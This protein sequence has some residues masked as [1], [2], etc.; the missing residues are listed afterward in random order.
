MLLPDRSHQYETALQR[1]YD[2]VH[3]PTLL[4]LSR[5]WYTKANK[6]GN[7]SAMRFAL[8]YAQ[9]VR[10]NL[11]HLVLPSLSRLT[12]FPSSEPSQALHINPSD[13]AIL[14]NVAMIQQKAAEMLVALPVDK[15]S[16]SEL[17]IAIEQATHAQKS[18]SSSPSPASTWSL[19][20]GL[21]DLTLS[22]PPPPPGSSLV[23]QDLPHAR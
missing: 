1:F 15:R 7:F 20:L 17:K 8:R 11:A 19:A 13:K 9:K 21:L 18:V 2:G 23:N 16:L 5:T 3:A 6:E 4:Y 12:N 10:S 22:P 14:F